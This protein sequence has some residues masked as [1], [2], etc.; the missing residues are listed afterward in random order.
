MNDFLYCK[1]EIFIPETHQEVLREAL[2]S[3]DA[4]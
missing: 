4:L 1:M 3:V 2:Q